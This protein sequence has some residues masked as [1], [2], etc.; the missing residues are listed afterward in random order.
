MDFQ[1][2]EEQRMLSDT[3]RRFVEAELYPYEQQVEDADELPAELRRQIIERALAAGL[4]AANMPEELGGGGLDTLSMCLL[5]RELGRANMALQYTV[6]R[7]SNILQACVGEQRDK[8]L[9]PCIRGEKTDCL[10][11]TEPGAGSDIRSM[12]CAAKRDAGGDYRINGVKHFI[13]HADVADFVIL[14]AATGV[15]Q[16]ARGPRKKITAF[17]VDKGAQGFS[18]RR[19]YRSVSHRGYHNFILEFDDC[20]V[21]AAQ[22]LGEVDQG[23]DVANQWLGNTRLQ[24]AAICLGRCDRAFELACDYAAT[25]KQFGQTIGKFQGVGFK[26]AD[27]EV[28]RRAA[29]LLTYQAAWREDHGGMT[30]MDAAMAKL[31]ATEAL[32]R[33][34]DEALQIHGGMG[35]M[36]DLPLE[37]IWRDARVERIWE[38]SSEIQR[39]IISRAILRPLE[40][41]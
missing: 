34:A 16:T 25:R 22:V 10:A 15:E 4:Y 9:Y 3:A 12:A 30:D 33:I 21:P 19:G 6:A 41:R 14:F 11:M 20:R 32:A 1:L 38:G 40:S 35:L 23:F 27:M 5:D 39:L 24:V 18:V 29:E 36:A 26:L 31:A 7:P 17:L 2:S 13:S 28:A 37:R 8:Y